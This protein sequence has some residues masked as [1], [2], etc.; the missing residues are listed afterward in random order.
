MVKADVAVKEDILHRQV[1]SNVKA[2]KAVLA[3][4]LVN[5]D[6]FSKVEDLLIDECF[7]ESVHKRIFQAIVTIINRGSSATLISMSSFFDDDVPDSENGIS[8]ADYIAHL[9]TNADIFI[10]IVD[11]SK[12]LYELHLR[13][14]IIKVNME[15]INLA[16]KND[17]SVDPMSEI[18]SLEQKIFNVTKFGIGNNDPALISYSLDLAIDSVK[19]A[20][21]RSDSDTLRGVSTG[22][23]GLDNLLGGMQ[24]SDLIILAGRPSMGKTALAINIALNTCEAV[25]KINVEKKL[26]GAERNSVVFFSLEMSSEQLAS[27]M[28]AM[29]SGI[30]SIKM[31]SGIINDGE[32]HKILQARKTL[33]E[34]PFL[35]D[36]SPAISISVLRT[37]IRRLKRRFNVSAVFID[38]LQLLKGSAHTASSGN[39]VQEVSEITQGLKAIAKEIDVPI[40]ALSQLSRALEQ[41]EDKRPQLAD[42]RDSGSIE[43]DADTVM[44]IYREE[45]YERRKQPA[46]GTPEHEKWQEKMCR[47]M[48]Q[49]D[50]I[51]AKQRNGPIGNIRLYFDSNTTKFTN[52]TNVHLYDY[53]D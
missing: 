34:L 23:T 9:V 14:E 26:S 47:I 6:E 20:H 22:F 43:Q 4:I 21:E 2:E 10:N 33:E 28:L 5:N 40:I 17:L 16:Y 37:K 15:S 1:P 27:R 32:Y 46:E 51:I 7:F 30:N 29:Q 49:S 11:I 36:D 13:R 41:R 53:A 31:R 3:A 19:A 12:L 8:I 42:L 38:Y 39:R 35:I 52:H 50:V 48:N 25:E 18:E 45:Y 44:F 24:K